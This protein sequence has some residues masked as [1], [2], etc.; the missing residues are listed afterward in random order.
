MAFA[1]GEVKKRA[2]WPELRQSIEAAVADVLGKMPKEP[3]DPQVKVVDEQTLGNCVRRRVNYFV[4]EW[5][6]VSAWMF[7][8]EDEID[9]PA[10][11][12]LHGRTPGGKDEPAGMDDA[13]RLLAFATH[14]ADRGFVTIAPD[15]IGCGERMSS[16]TQPFDTKSFYKENSKWTAMGKILWDHMRCLDVLSEMKEVDP[17]RIGVIGHGLGGAHALMLGAF[18]DR[19]RAIVS[20][21]GF[22]PFAADADPGRW[23]RED[24]FNLM[25]KLKAAIESREY[26]FDW[27]HILALVA[28]NPALLITSSADEAIAKPEI[29][30]ERIAQIRKIYKLLGAA[31]AVDHFTHKSGAKMTAAALEAADEWFDRWL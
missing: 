2:E 31:D 11:L 14:Y 10:V 30:D 26:P 4:D 15:S 16:R 25:P 3:I 13:D 17:G 1:L 18:D 23:A 6:R 28:P 9:L 8:P 29:V 12:C 22:L 24:N 7:V 5:T 19:V 27:D 20:S 21:A